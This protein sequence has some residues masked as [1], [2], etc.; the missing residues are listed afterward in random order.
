MLIVFEGVNGSGKTTLINE[1]VKKLVSLK[2]NYIIFKYPD[3]K[4]SKTG[5]TINQYLKSEVK[6]NDN[7]MLNM[8]FQNILE[9]QH[10]IKHY[11]LLGYYVICDRYI[12]STIV[13]N[14][15]NIYDRIF[16]EGVHEHIFNIEYYI[17]NYYNKLIKP[18]IVF[19]I[20]GDHLHLRNEEK[21]KYHYV[22]NN[23]DFLFNFINI[24]INTNDYYHVIKNE[25]NKLDDSSKKIFNLLLLN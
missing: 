12:Y 24:F 21:E 1:L 19:L 8:F 2:K 22:K 14:Y 3:R 9:T 20:N 7:F 15:K 16:N 11:I 10:L 13:Y 4:S 18:D 6:I 5:L 25:N 23:N 17:K